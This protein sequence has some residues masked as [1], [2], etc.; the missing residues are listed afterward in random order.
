ACAAGRPAAGVRAGQDAGRRRGDEGGGRMVRVALG[1]TA[2]PGRVSATGDWRLYDGGGRSVLVRGG[3]GDVWTV[4]RQ[5]SL[6][7]AVRADG[8]PSVLR[9]G[10]LVLRP[11]SA[12]ALVA[13]NGRRYRGEIALHATDGGILAVNRVAVED[14]LRG[15]V[16]LEIG[17]RSSAEHAAVEAQAVAAR[18]YTY[19]RLGAG[20]GD[21]RDA[22]DARDARVALGSGGATRPYDLLSTVDDQVYG[23]ADAERPVTDAAVAATAGEVITYAGRVVNAP[24]HS[25]C[26]GSTAEVAEVWWREPPEPYLKRVS[27]RIPG[28]ADRYYCDQSPRFRWTRSYDAASLRATLERYL[29]TYASVPSGGIGSVRFVATTGTTPSGRA[30]GLRVE[31]DRG[32]YLLRGNDVRY[33][34]RTS[35]GEILNSTYF[36]VEPVVGRDGHLSQLTIRGAGYGHGI[37]MC[38]WGAI[39]RARAGQDYRTILRTYYPGT[40]LG[41]AE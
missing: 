22:R 10:P 9:E 19:V 7:R 31:T 6:M 11:V 16:P 24:Y 38:Q 33:V 39:G 3:A 30:A 32:G 14:Y 34:L 37:G 2:G 29:R 28:T 13:W 12:G 5:G 26:G 20:P 27:D 1:T 41:R 25:T 35:G 18:S 40:A 21:T 17:A 4:E 8:V 36:S 23:G 15:V